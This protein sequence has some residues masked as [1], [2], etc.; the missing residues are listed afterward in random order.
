MSGGLM[1]TLALAAQELAE[2]GGAC[3]AGRGQG[4]RMTVLL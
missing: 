4:F 3:S 1:T 2:E